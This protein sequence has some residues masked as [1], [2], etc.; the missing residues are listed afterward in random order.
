MPSKKRKRVGYID[1]AVIIENQSKK[2]NAAEH[3]KAVPVNSSVNSPERFFTHKLVVYSSDGSSIDKTYFEAYVMNNEICVLIAPVWDS[4]VLSV[5]F[6]SNALQAKEN[7]SGKRKKGAFKCNAG[8]SLCTITF[9]DGSST[10]LRCPIGGQVLELN[11]K[12]MDQ[13]SLMASS[14]I[15]KGYIGAMFPFTKLPSLS[16]A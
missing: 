1:R 5:E 3:I 8:A 7:I 15:G 13:P 11:E 16:S 4:A 10:V 6:N 2:Q 14:R 12:L 9:A